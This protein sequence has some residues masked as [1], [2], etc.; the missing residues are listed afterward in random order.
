MSLH[1]E[2]IMASDLIFVY[3]RQASLVA[4]YVENYL[5]GALEMVIWFSHRSDWVDVEELF[6]TTFVR[7]ELIGAPVLRD[8]E[9][10]AIAT[11]PRSHENKMS[12]G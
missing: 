2:A 6:L 7:V 1:P 9:L 10:L 12:N 4:M 5:G 3:P 8:Y 11:T